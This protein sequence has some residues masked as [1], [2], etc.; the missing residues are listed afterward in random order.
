ML[1]FHPEDN[2]TAE[3]CMR[4]AQEVCERTKLKDYP[5]FGVGYI[6][7]QLSDTLYDFIYCRQS[8]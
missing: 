3:D 4:I 1:S 2:V 8:S 7:P 6:M 5:Y